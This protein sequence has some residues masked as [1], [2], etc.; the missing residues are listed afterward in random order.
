MPDEIAALL[1]GE[2]GQRARDEL[3]DLVE[4]PRSRGAEPRFQLREGEFDR[5][6]IRAVRRQEAE[7]CADAFDGGLHLRLLV[8]RQIIED[9]HVARPQRRHEDLLDVR[10]EAG[11][12]E[13]SIED[14]RRVEAVDPQGRD[15]GVSL[16]VPT[17]GVIAHA[18]PTRTAA[19]PPQQVGGDARRVQEDVSARIVER[20][21]ILPVSPGGR[22]ISA[23]LFVGVDRFF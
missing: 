14:R 12:V 13:R 22:D 5:I 7:P 10:Q 2:E 8:E 3:D 1:W 4:A 17:R 15:H 6:E 11:V 23:P 16:P 21:R 9:H 19:I 20:L 18:L